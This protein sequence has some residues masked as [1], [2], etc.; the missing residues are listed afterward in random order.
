[1]GNGVAWIGGDARGNPMAYY[2]E[3]YIPGRISTHAIEEQW[4]GYSTITD[5]VAYV[6]SRD[7]HLFWVIHFP[8][9]NATW[10]YDLVEKSWHE[11]G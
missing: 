5:A 9:G 8:T 10:V 4:G 11:R 2:C 3:G 6:E 7:G 1:M